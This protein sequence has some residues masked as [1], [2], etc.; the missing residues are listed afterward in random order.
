MWSMTD[1][2]NISMRL[3]YD[4]LTR[5]GGW[6]NDPRNKTPYQC[7]HEWFVNTVIKK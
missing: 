1:I 6:W 5:V 7:R 2:Q 4:V 3:G